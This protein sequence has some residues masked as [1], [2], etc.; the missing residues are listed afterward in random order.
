[1][2]FTE[3]SSPRD[4][5]FDKGHP[6]FLGVMTEFTKE[7]ITMNEERPYLAFYGNKQIEVVATSS[8]AA[9]VK[10]ASLLKVSDKKRYLIIVKLADVIHSTASLG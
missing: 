1:L 10:A 8:Y 9:Q 4:G 7:I 6:V 3:Y 5:V 2:T